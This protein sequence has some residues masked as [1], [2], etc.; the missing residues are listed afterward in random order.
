[1]ND[2]WKWLARANA[3]SVLIALVI[4]LLLVIGWWVWKELHPARVASAMRGSVQRETK[5]AD[6]G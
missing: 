5:P 2:F 3:K 1:M 4:A 6:L